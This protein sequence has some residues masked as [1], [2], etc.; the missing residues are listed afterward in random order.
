MLRFARRSRRRRREREDAPAC[1][2]SIPRNR[3]NTSSNYSRNAWTWNCPSR[4]TTSDFLTPA[5]WSQLKSRNRVRRHHRALSTKTAEPASG[6]RFRLSFLVSRRHRRRS[7][8]VCVLPPSRR[9][10]STVGHETRTQNDP[11][12][13]L[14]PHRYALAFPTTQVWENLTS[15]WVSDLPFQV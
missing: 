15:V 10:R 7:R 2:S 1:Y 8:C 5:R 6:S 3:W 12:D 9:R 11:V 13:G 14:V 4:V